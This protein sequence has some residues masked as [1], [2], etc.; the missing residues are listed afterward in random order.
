MRKL[1][2]LI[3]PPLC[4]LV[5]SIPVVILTNIDS[6]QDLLILLITYVVAHL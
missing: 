5:A 1:L 4:G 2:N 6:N 3:I